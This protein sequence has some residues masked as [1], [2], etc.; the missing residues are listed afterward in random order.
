MSKETP[1]GCEKFL[2]HIKTNVCC[3]NAEHYSC[4]MAWLADAVQNPTKRGGTAVVLRG[5]QGTGKSLFGKAIGKL[6][7]QH[8]SQ[9]SDL[10]HLVGS[11]N[12]HL[13]DC[14]LLLADEAFLSDD[15]RSESILKALITEEHIVIEKKG[16][17]AKL[18]PNYIHLIIASNSEWT[19]PVTMD[20]RR[21]FVLDVADN[22]CRDSRYFGDIIE[23]LENGGYGALWQQLM[24]VDLTIGR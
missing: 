3:G 11:F 24:T 19:T 10:R 13:Q 5:K 23:E 22:H 6:F 16:F 8:F 18:H 9:V 1:T 7:N 12:N 14:V 17:D 21:F 20:A 2:D 4:L 15:R